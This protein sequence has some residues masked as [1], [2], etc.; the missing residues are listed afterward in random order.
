MKNFVPKL[1]SDLEIVPTHYEG[2]RVL[3]VRDFLGLIGNPVVLQE[4]ALILIGLIDGRRTVSD[5]QLEFVR[6]KGGVFVGSEFIA[7]FLEQLDSAFLLE[8]PKYFQGKAKLVAEYA[9]LRVRSASHAGQSYPEDKQELNKYLDSILGLATEPALPPEGKRV[10]GVISPHIDLEAGKRV[11]ASIYRA[12]HG[13]SPRRVF[14]LGT[15]HSLEGSLVGLTEKDFE[16]PLGRVKND[17][18]IVRELKSAGGDWLAGQDLAFRQEHSLEFQ[19]IFLQHLFGSDFTLVPILFGSFQ[20]TLESFERPSALPGLG[21]WL[22]L[23]K[24]HVEGEAGKT[25][26][27]AGVDFSHIGPKFGHRSRAISL[28]LEAREHDRRL[29][30]A[31]ERGDVQSFWAESRRVLDKYNVCGFSTL[32]CLLEISPGATGRLLAYEFWQE[33]ATQSAVSFAGMIIIK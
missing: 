12:V 24:K 17:K 6:Q 10:W 1:R 3:L 2:Q 8:S 26:V 25:L 14:L 20:E 33:E 13:L 30:N 28:I 31:C 22:E 23:L 11:Y 16:T 27:V 5:I 19:L 29:I 32:A 15:G 18:R 4:D 21:P 7:N 9:E